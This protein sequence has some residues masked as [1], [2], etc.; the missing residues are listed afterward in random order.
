VDECRTPGSLCRPPNVD[1]Y[2]LIKDLWR[3][4][5]LH[6]SETREL[7]A[8]APCVNSCQRPGVPSLKMGSE[9]LAIPQDTS[10][11]QFDQQAGD[12]KLCGARNR[13][14]EIRPRQGTPS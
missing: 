1:L 3:Q 4:S 7:E 8:R 2:T 5:E 9:G 13:G 10:R 6:R 14:A 11:E 12:R